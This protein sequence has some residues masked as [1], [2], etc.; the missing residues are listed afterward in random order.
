MSNRPPH[1][2]EHAPPATEKIVPSYRSLKAHL[3]FW[4]V[5]VVGVVLDLASKNWAVNTLGNPEQA[6]PKP[7]IIL[8]GWL[9]F[10]T[11]FNTGAVGGFAAGKTTFLLVITL[12]ALIFLLWL[13]ATTPRDNH[14]CHFFLGLIMA[15][16][17]GNMHDRLF[18]HGK[19]IDFI[20]VN[21]HFNPFNP[22]PTFNLA[23]TFL[24][25]GAVL[26]VIS[27]IRAGRQHKK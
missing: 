21:L 11:V 13:F 3:V 25:I 14:L 26:F 20:E 2:K 8:D 12:L 7:F 18:N 5:C 27:L 24:T 16:A 1:N 6:Q 19:V 4:L 17:L 15:G 10:I 23:D 9:R 22:W